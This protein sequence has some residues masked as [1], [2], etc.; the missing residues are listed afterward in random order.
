MVKKKDEWKSGE[1]RPGARS[2]ADILPDVGLTPIHL[3][4]FI[5]NG[6]V[7]NVSEIKVK[8]RVPSALGNLEVVLSSHFGLVPCLVLRL[9]IVFC[10]LPHTNHAVERQCHSISNQADGRIYNE[11]WRH[12]AGGAIIVIQVG[13][14]VPICPEGREWIFSKVLTF[15]GIAITQVSSDQPHT[16]RQC[17]QQC[18]DEQSIDDTSRHTR[19]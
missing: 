18:G 6:D 16:A 13:Q 15:L 11:D 3:A 9:R 14:A 17:Q 1:R 10:S 4:F 2:A 7:G 12:V 5:S 19:F 8:D